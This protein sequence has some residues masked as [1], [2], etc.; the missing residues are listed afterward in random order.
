MKN[1]KY[2]LFSILILF[3]NIF[4]VNAS[5]TDDE[6]TSLKELAKD[7]KVSYKHKGK[8]ETDERILYNLFD[9]TVKNLTNEFYVFL[10]ELSTKL[11]SEDGGATI[12]LDNGI[13]HFKIYSSQCNIEV[14]EI[15]VFLPKFNLFS[16]D[17][18]CE[19]I[20]GD[21]FPLCGK[22]YEEDITYDEFEKSVISYREKNKIDNSFDSNGLKIL[23]NKIVRFVIDYKIY[24][25]V[26]VIALFLLIIMFI[27]IRRNKKRG[28]L[29]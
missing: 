15:N 20:N 1:I 4:Y 10:P 8:V 26:S 25:I 7:I 2:L 9:V 13:W 28:V 24:F 29:E 6:I 19:G 18:L 17:P 11:I 16:L 22:Y 5:C 12:E 3:L 23:I 27:V 21:D 14:D